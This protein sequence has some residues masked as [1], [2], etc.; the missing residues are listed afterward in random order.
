MKYNLQ[1]KKVAVLATDG[2]EEPELLLPVEALR[3]AGAKTTVVSLKAGRIRGWKDDGWGEWVDVDITLADADAKDYHA[4]LLPGG[5]L[6]P[7]KLRVDEDVLAF[8]KPFFDQK[9]PVAAICHGPWTLINA[10]VVRDRRV[11]SWPSLKQD[12]TNAGAHWED[13]ECVCDEALVTSRSPDDIPAF[14]ANF[15]DKIAQSNHELQ[16]V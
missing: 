13:A 7:D 4:L 10:G 9:K 5:V 3:Q 16:T 1:G 12:L 2:F 14:T 11:T 6:N 8:V 15:C